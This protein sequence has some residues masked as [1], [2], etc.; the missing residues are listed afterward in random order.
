MQR[1]ISKYS[2]IA[3]EE[4][5]AICNPVCECVVV[6]PVCDP[7]ELADTFV[8]EMEDDAILMLLCA[9]AFDPP[10]VPYEDD[11]KRNL[12]S[13]S[14]FLVHPAGHAASANIITLPDQTNAALVTDSF[15]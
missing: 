11:P 9:W 10:V 13:R 15:P 8:V 2:G 6:V 4:D 14:E 12:P 1:I 7:D 3:V 5:I